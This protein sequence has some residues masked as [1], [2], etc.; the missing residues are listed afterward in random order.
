MCQD[1]EKFRFGKLVS[2]STNKLEDL[3][4]WPHTWHKY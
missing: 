3:G 1:I 2:F 4:M